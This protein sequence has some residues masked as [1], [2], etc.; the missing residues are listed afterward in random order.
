MSSRRIPERNISE[1]FL[2]LIVTVFLFIISLIHIKGRKN[3][4]KIRIENIII[5]SVIVLFLLTVIWLYN[6]LIRRRNNINYALSSI[7]ALLKKRYDLIPGLVS[8]VRQY[9][10]YEK[11]LLNQLTELRARAIIGDLSTMEREKLAE[12]TG[13]LLKNIIA[14]E[15]NYPD[16]KA[17]HN[18]LQ[19]V[20]VIL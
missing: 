1:I 5:V 8:T 16:L 11:G 18:Y 9:M 3:M 19:L 4:D 15:E 7:D 20:F 10:Q 13:R 2:S 14:I 12:E 17:S 6:S